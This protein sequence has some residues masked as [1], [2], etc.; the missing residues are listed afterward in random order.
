MKRK[1][2]ERN[3]DRLDPIYS[4]TRKLEKRPNRA[5]LKR[6]DPKVSNENFFTI[7]TLKNRPTEPLYTF[8]LRLPSSRKKK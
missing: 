4:I 2:F 3:Q 5:E 1:K 6:K 8:F 7:T